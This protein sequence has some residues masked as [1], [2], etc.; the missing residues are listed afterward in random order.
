MEAA[1]IGLALALAAGCGYVAAHDD[2]HGTGIGKP[3]EASNVS[4]TIDVAMSDTMRFAPSEIRVR[5]GETI[6]FVVTNAG[7][8][9]HEMVLGTASDLRKHAELMKKYPEMHHEDPNHMSLDPGRSGE[10]VWQFTESG[11]VE[12]ACLQPGHFDAG[13]KGRIVVR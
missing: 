1:R 13:M 4:R 8:V 9:K 11:V 10:I 6:R 7:K 3:G 12:F 2:P 5:K